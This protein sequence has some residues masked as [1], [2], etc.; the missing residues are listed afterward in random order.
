[1]DQQSVG[2]VMTGTGMTSMGCDRASGPSAPKLSNHQRERLQR[3]LAE[4]Q[5][6]TTA[7]VQC[8]I[9]ASF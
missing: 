8:L 1:M 3:V 5:P 2:G 4:Y 9:G 6:W 7:E